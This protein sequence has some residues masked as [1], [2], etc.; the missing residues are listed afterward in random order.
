MT[1]DN[2]EDKRVRER[3]NC[4]ESSSEYL[5]VIRWAASTKQE[6]LFLGKWPFHVLTNHTFLILLKVSMFSEFA[7]VDHRVCV[8]QREMSALAT[9]TNEEEEWEEVASVGSVI[10]VDSEGIES[11]GTSTLGAGTASSL[12]SAEVGS[13]PG[14]PS[15]SL[16]GAAGAADAGAFAAGRD[17]SNNTNESGSVSDLDSLGDELDS[18]SLDSHTDESAGT[19]NEPPASSAAGGTAPRLAPLGG[20]YAAFDSYARQQQ[21]VYFDGCSEKRGGGGG[22]Y[23]Y[24][25]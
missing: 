24:Q 2:F 1:F 5:R 20:T 13:A 10:S 19:T 11:L 4:S 25:S 3:T 7:R 6:N 23:L 18:L 17:G 8:V 9:G 21:V 12:D 14:S 15:S 16:S 22:L